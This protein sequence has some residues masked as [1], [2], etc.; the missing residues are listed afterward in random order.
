MCTCAWS[1][2]FFLVDS[3]DRYVGALIGKGGQFISRLESEFEVCIEIR[4]GSNTAVIVG[5]TQERVNG[6]CV[7]V[8]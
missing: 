4:R 7:R 5:R 1:L 8:C 3:C 2:F 6:A